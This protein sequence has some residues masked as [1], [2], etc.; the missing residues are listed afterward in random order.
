MP[1]QLTVTNCLHKT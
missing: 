1:F